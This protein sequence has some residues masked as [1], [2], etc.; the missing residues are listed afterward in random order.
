MPEILT[1]NIPFW[2]TSWWLRTLLVAVAV[3]LLP[4]LFSRLASPWRRVRV[5]STV[6]ATAA[7]KES[8]G[9]RIVTYN[10]AHG[11]GLAESN[12]QGG[13]A[14]ERRERLDRIGDLLK[15]LNADVVVLNEVDFQS[16]WSGGVN[17]A[18]YLAKRA[19]YPHWAEE[20]NLDFR[21]LLWTWQ[22]G[23]AVLSRFPIS[24]AREVPLPG[25]VWWET[26]VAGKKR[27]V[28]CE[29][30]VPGGPLRMI[31]A[32][33]AHRSEPVRVSAAKVLAA[34]AK[35]SELPLVVAGD[36]NST[37]PGFPRA[38]TSGENA[39]E[40][41]DAA[42]CFQRSPLAAPQA[43]DMTYPS[44]HG[45]SV[46]DWILIPKTWQF[47]DYRVIESDHSDHRPIFA[48]IAPSP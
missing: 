37:P 3:L 40:V 36:L 39:I 35:Q 31:G 38:N 32:H 1:V 26:I 8:S 44:V 34:V 20:R 13:S 43:A 33:L 7:A 4:Y 22:F 24:S 6:G 46:I 47:R 21:V 14:I 19:G 17:Q 23:N 29:I 10:I 5:R 48:E 15:E 25:E 18:E 12:W 2:P 27:A 28:L 41:L 45:E 30:D 16:S 9:L 42:G 11:R